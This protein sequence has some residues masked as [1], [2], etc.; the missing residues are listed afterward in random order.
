MTK[1]TPGYYEFCAD[2]REAVTGYFEEFGEADQLHRHLNDTAGG[3]IWTMR[4]M[5][6]DAMG[7]HLDYNTAVT[8]LAD[9]IDQE[10]IG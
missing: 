3:W 1:S 5:T 2:N 7:I 6:G 9:A 8:P 10:Q 4:E